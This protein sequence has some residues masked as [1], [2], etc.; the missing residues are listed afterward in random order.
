MTFNGRQPL[1]KKNLD[2]R[3]PW[4][5]LEWK[6]TLDQRGP[7]VEEGLGWQATFDGGQPLVADNLRY[8]MTFDGRR[9]LM[10]YDLIWKRT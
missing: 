6:M 5:N 1:I 9:S 7:W 8:D 2:P 10:E 3:Q 4:D